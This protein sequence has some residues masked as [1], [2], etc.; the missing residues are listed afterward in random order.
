MPYEIE[1]IRFNSAH[2]G[3]DMSQ[4]QRSRRLTLVF[5]RLRKRKRAA[6]QAARK[7]RSAEENAAQ[8]R[9]QIQPGAAAADED[10]D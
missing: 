10:K 2:P 9:D 8:R 7:A 4:R 5:E 1:T 6:K 3:D